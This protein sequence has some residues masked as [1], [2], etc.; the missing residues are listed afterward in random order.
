LSGL[1]T[2]EALDLERITLVQRSESEGRS[3]AVTRSW[4]KL[5][6]ARGTG[7]GIFMLTPSAFSLLH[8]GPSKDGLRSLL[9]SR[10]SFGREA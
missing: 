4:A 7:G 1:L 5:I 2:V 6:Q 9:E 8:P 3:A 10:S